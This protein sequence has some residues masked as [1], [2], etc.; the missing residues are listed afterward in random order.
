MIGVL[1]CLDGLKRV[2]I[3]LRQ[4]HNITLSVTH[5]PTLIIVSRSYQTSRIMLRRQIVVG[6]RTRK[7]F[8]LCGSQWRQT[9]MSCTR[10]STF[11]RRSENQQ[12]NHAMYMY[13]VQLY[14]CTYRPVFC[15]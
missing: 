15:E 14:N 5:R 7:Y 4:K 12:I 3:L 2:A 6:D 10:L 13:N 1:K 9:L 8:K 11:K